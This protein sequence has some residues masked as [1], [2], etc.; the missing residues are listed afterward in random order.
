V[1][2]IVSGVLAALD[3]PAG[4]YNLADDCPT[5]QNTLIEAACRLL[6]RTPPPLMT[7]DQANLS[8]MALGFYAETRR[9]ANGKARR[10]LGWVSRFPTYREGLAGLLAG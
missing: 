10:L 8:P 3:A 1:D 2:D 4:V 5:S 6:R 9:V 7:L